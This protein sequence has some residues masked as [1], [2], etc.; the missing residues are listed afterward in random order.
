VTEPTLPTIQ[1]EMK[2]GAFNKWMAY[3]LLQNSDQNKYGPMINGLLSQFSM[4]NNQYPKTITAATDIMSKHKHD[5]WGNPNKK[6][7]W[8][9]TNK[10]EGENSPKN[11]NESKETSFAQNNK[12]KTCYCCG[13]KGHTSPECKEK[14]TRQ[15]ERRLGIQ[16]SRTA[17][18]SS[19]SG[20]NSKDRQ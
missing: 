4:G 17:Y 10:E 2:V 20:R 6:K 11:P 19:S 12:D 1:K 5:S 8:S 7:S 16:K 15:K 14:N 18:A 3:L 9:N 13:K